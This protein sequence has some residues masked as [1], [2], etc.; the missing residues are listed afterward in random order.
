[1]SLQYGN[2][3][4]LVCGATGTVW[5]VRNEGG[6]LRIP[7]S[8]VL[9]TFQTSEV[10]EVFRPS[11]RVLSDIHGDNVMVLFTADLSTDVLVRADE[12][13]VYG[14]H[15]R[16]FDSAGRSVCLCEVAVC[17]ALGFLELL[18]GEGPVWSEGL[19]D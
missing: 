17:D 19:G 4:K 7:G 11:Y 15:D 8:G 2:F 3:V 12:V 16:F 14:N 9:K 6:Q 1:M 5:V 10:A 18:T 13:S